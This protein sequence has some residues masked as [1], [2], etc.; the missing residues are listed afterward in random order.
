MLE[1]T[2]DIT[3]RKEAEDARDRYLKEL[4]DLKAQLEEEN[5]YLKEEIDDRQ[6][7]KEIVGRSN[8]ILYVL[9]KVR[10]VAQTDA[11]VLVQGET[12]VGKE[13][14]ARAIHRTGGRMEKPFVTVNC[15]ALPTGLVESELFGHEAGAF[16]GAGAQRKGRF[17]LADGG[18]VFLD[19]ISEMPL[20]VQAKLLRVLQEGQFERVGSS[21][22]LKVDAR[23]IAA[24]NRNLAEEVAE[25]RFRPDL[26]YRLN[27]YP[28]T[29]P[30]LRA[31]RE[32]VPLLVQ[33]FVPLIAA[34]TG[35]TVDQVPPHVME[36]LKSHDWPGNVRELV[37]LL[38]RVVI[39][40]SDSVIRLPEE[41]ADKSNPV[42]K[43]AQAQDGPADLDSVERNHII[44]VL[45]TVD[46]RISGPKGAAK[47]L[48][49][50]PSTLRFR[51]KKL[52]IRKSERHSGNG[53]EQKLDT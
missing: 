28:I 32:D 53:S 26:Y 39:T 7:F 48:G 50:N 51:M 27:V 19:E 41:I 38:E 5:I 35:K 15:A 10:Q 24:T 6:G 22:S 1:A 12:G 43:S 2:T 17:E 3:G 23:V 18:T 4:E 52:G 36:S 29:V 13:L 9:E 34:R 33:H 20:D 16:T 40:S 45:N 14:V 21:R 46:W 44:V 42:L 11:T 25:G 8:A 47:I 49:L 37:N 30:P 31:R